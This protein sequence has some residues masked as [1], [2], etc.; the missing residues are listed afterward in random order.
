MLARGALCYLIGQEG[1]D[2]LRRIEFSSEEKQAIQDARRANRD[3][4]VERRLKALW[5]KAEG[6]KHAEIS[7]ETEYHSAYITKLVNKFREG[8]MEA[9]T[10][11]HYKGNR[12]NMSFEEE[13]RL[14]APFR[15]KDK[16]GLPVDVSEIKAAYG[17]ALGR[18]VGTSQIYNVLHRHDWQKTMP[19]GRRLQQDKAEGSEQDSGNTDARRKR[20]AKKPTDA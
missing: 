14:L 5:M 11:N 8:G 9:I 17:E 2:K 13:E 15:E 6:K 16:A 18:S 19:R 10:G 3:K 20:R 7:A 12:R 1:K 4:N